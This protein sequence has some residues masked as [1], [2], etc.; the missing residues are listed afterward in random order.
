MGIARTPREH[1]VGT[2][3][4]RAAHL[5]VAHPDTVV[6]TRTQSFE[7]GLLRGEARGEM[8]LGLRL[9]FAVGALGLREGAASERGRALEDPPH[10]GDLNDIDAKPHLF[11]GDSSFLHIPRAFRA[12][13]FVTALL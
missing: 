13:V 4:A 6:K 2:A 8:N 11:V 5:D 10:A 3:L 12:L 1:H 9:A 7:D